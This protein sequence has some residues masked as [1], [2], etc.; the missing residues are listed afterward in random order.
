MCGVPRFD[1]TM[2]DYYCERKTGEI[3]RTQAEKAEVSGRPAAKSLDALRRDGVFALRTPQDYG[4]AWASAESVAG[5]LSDLGRPGS[6][7]R[8]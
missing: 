3:L 4:G 6:P 5:C 1:R 8:A 7:V 2:I